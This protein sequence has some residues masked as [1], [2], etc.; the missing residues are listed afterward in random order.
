[1][2][3][4]AKRASAQEIIVV[5][6][7]FGYARQDRKDRSRVPISSSVMAQAIEFAGADKICTIDIHS[8]QL[9]G[10]VKAPW[11]NLY[12]SYCMLPRLEQENFKDLVIA[13]PDKGGVPTATAY[14]KRLDASGVAIVYKV[15][16]VV[17]HDQTEA[18]DIIGD[19]GGKEVLLVD[20]IVTTAG[21]LCNAAE[22]IK[23]KGAKKIW[24]AV[25]HG[26]FTEGALEKIIASPIEK[27]LITDTV[28]QRKEVV[29]CPKVEVVSI[30]NL[31]AEAIKRIESGQ[32]ISEKLILR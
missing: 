29:D 18:L 19:V 32:S 7:Y 3:D 27:I 25:T 14:A 30:S 16:D 6:P 1:M 28:P 12:S 15:R 11:D 23:Q 21:T 9:Q 24:A 10:F 26:V 13:S 31:L 2:I 4:A 5:I 22:L 8:E 17:N 20:D